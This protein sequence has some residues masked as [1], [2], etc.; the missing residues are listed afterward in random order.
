MMRHHLRVGDLL[1][2]PVNNA[3]GLITKATRSYFYFYLMAID[4]PVTNE[5]ASRQTVYRSVD[6][7]TIIAHYGSLKRRRKRKIYV[8][9]NEK[10]C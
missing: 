1:Y 9:I 4:A 3:L 10:D 5:R 6:N 8:D 7:G 2:N